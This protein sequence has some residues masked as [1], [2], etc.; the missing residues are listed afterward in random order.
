MALLLMS[1]LG[2]LPIMPESRTGLPVIRFIANGTV[3]PRG[4][5]ELGRYGVQNDV[6]NPI[7][8]GTRSDQR[9]RKT[10]DI[11]MRHRPG[12][13]APLEAGSREGRTDFRRGVA[14]LVLRPAPAT[15]QAL[16]YRIDLQRS[17]P[18][19][20]HSQR[21]GARYS[22]Y[23]ARYLSM[24]SFANRGREKSWCSPG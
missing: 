13:V 20:R 7:D 1:F 5:P 18:E 6:G 15:Y 14:V 23:H 16:I 11:P 12:D 17:Q 19:S 10:G 22:P 3:M 8:F 9:R 4:W 21:A 2:R 24:A